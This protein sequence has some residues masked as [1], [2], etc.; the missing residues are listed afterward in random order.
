MKPIYVEILIQGDIE[1][2]W[3]KTQDPGLHQ[4][5]DLRFT[6][7]EYL[8]RPENIIAQRFL[9]K[10]RIAFG[11]E[12]SGEGETV[13]EALNKTNRTSALRFCSKDPKSLILEGSGYWKYIAETKSTRFLT[14][15]DYSTRFG[16][17]GQIFDFLV[18]RPMLG[19][20]TAWSFD[21]LRLWVEQDIPPSIVFRCSLIH[22]IVR[23][24]TAFVW[25]YHGLV[26]KILF[27]H[28]D[29]IKMLQ[30]SGMTENANLFLFCFGLVEILFGLVILFSKRLKRILIVNIFLLCV[31]LIIVSVFSAEY[32]ISAFNPVSLNVAIVAL[33]FIGILS[34]TAMAT[35]RQ[36][37]RKATK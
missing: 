11:L 27:R 29:E 21:R 7:I 15:Y 9:Y 37:L 4:Q 20:A 30:Q 10:T 6:E 19:W 28:A 24:T 23:L 14:S 5:W 31:A 3:S 16:K 13:G 12:I 8:P 35:P 1:D 25:I 33:S 36:C 26:P 32:L 17:L 18:F 2:V 22:A 34:E